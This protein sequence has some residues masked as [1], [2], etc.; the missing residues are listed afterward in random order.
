MK[1]TS[2]FILGI[3]LL[4]LLL[5][6]IYIAKC[7]LPKTEDN[8]VI[9]EGKGGGEIIEESVIPNQYILSFSDSILE[10]D[11]MVPLDTATIQSLIEEFTSQG[12]TVLKECMCKKMVLIAPIFPVTP[13]ERQQE[14]KAKLDPQGNG[15]G[16]YGTSSLNYTLQIRPHKSDSVEF[17]YEFNYQDI[18]TRTPLPGEKSVKV[19]ILDT[20]FDPSHSLLTSN[21]WTN[22]NEPIDSSDDDEN[23]IIDDVNGVNI[24]T[25]EPR[26]NLSD[27]HGT[28][29]AGKV[30]NVLGDGYPSDVY[31]QMMSVK[32]TSED[33]T[34]NRQSGNLFDAVCG[35]RYSI[36]QDASVI[37][38][39]F[40]VQLNTPSI[41]LE[42]VLKI[43]EKKNVTIIAAAGNAGKDIDSLPFYP[44]SYAGIAGFENVISVGAV[45]NS[46]NLASFSNYGKKSV[47]LAA[48]GV[49]Q[50]ILL[51]S[52]PSGEGKMDGT[53]IAVPIVAS[54]VSIIKA[55]RPNISPTALRL[56]LF[57]G[58]DADSLLLTQINKG[59]F[60]PDAALDAC[61]IPPL[62]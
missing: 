22:Q 26:F 15:I 29:V 10:N 32:F 59:I 9:E 57:K 27:G 41:L 33:P 21:V 25:H 13:Q 14:A 45:N 30:L 62:E 31:L 55:H 36:S 46:N 18:Y 19:A 53:S 49:Q 17:N 50:R 2:K 43:A 37:T 38:A 61:D 16:K 56:C 60:N 35:M 58:V 3:L 12:D 51:S 52:S 39:S 34:T 7:D 1:K 47:L 6:I 40:G 11:V 28:A 20:G 54:T 23:C 48:P 4:L 24:P 5:I 44:A 8:P 42:D